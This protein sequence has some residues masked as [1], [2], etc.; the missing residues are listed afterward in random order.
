MNINVIMQREH[1]S[2]RKKILTWLMPLMLLLILVDSTLLNRLAIGALEKELDAD[3]YSSTKEMAAYLN[4]TNLDAKDFEMLEN[5]SQILLKDEVDTVIYSVSNAQ[6]KLLNGNPQLSQVSPSK[7]SRLN[8]E[9]FLTEINRTQYRVARS[10]FWVRSGSVSHQLTV[11]V[12][13]TMNRRNALASKILIGVVLPQLL[14]VLLTYFIIL[15]GVKK[16][17]APL[18]SLQNEVLARSEQNL[19]PIDLPNIPKEVALVARSINQLM[20]QLQ[21]SISAQNNFIANAAHQLRTPLAGAQAQLE[22]AEIESD[23]E[24]LQSIFV[25]VRQSLDRLLHTINQ[26]LILARSQPEALPMIKMELIDLNLISKEIVLLMLPTAIHKQIDLGFEQSELPV[27][28]KG[29][30]ERLRELLYN[31][32]DNAIRYTQEGG[33]VT[34]ATK[35]SADGV[36]LIVEDNGP[37]VPVA[38]RDKIFDRFHRVV[39]SEQEGSGLGLAIVQEIAKL[40]GASISLTDASPDGGL[41][42]TVLFNRLEPSLS[43]PI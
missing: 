24:V 26:L 38:E 30:E 29:N 2:L 20:L 10:S 16:G 17:L 4:H 14:L 19:S 5:F 40:H 3:L 42:I 1:L 23:P 6:G 34:V 18:N 36:A 22:L 8:P 35:V 33:R 21:N 32:L 43:L 15:I 11:Q 41:K 31:L 9:F 7:L 13:T 25:K 37:G 12:A 28:I 27:V 39:G